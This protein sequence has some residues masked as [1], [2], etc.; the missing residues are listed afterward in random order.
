MTYLIYYFHIL[1]FYKFFY[2][3][4]KLKNQMRFSVLNL[5]KNLVNSLKP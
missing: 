5:L 4:N 1:Y 2:Y 3:T